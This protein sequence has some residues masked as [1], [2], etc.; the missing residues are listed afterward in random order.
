MTRRIAM[1]IQSENAEPRAW[2]ALKFII[3]V[4]YYNLLHLLTLLT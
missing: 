1:K 2:L 4:S 3:N